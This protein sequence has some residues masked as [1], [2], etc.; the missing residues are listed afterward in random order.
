MGTGQSTPQAP[1]SALCQHRSGSGGFPFG[2]SPLHF[3]CSPLHPTKAGR[4]QT[5]PLA[6]CSNISAARLVASALNRPV[7]IVSL[8]VKVVSPA[9]AKTMR[10]LT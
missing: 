9:E 8:I 7:A 6:C 2:C 1:G 3:G 5:R 10:S 4:T